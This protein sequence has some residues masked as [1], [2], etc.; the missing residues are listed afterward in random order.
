MTL[1]QVAPAGVAG[2]RD[3]GGNNHTDHML[4]PGGGATEVR[5][6]AISERRDSCQGWS[7]QITSRSDYVGQQRPDL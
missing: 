2:S 5:P 1:P 4:L 7:K 3:E 6:L